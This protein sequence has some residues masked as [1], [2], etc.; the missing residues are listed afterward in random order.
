MYHTYWLAMLCGCLDMVS[1]IIMH[2]KAITMYPLSYI[3]ASYHYSVFLFR[4]KICLLPVIEMNQK[5]A[6]VVVVSNSSYISLGHE[7]YRY[8]SY[9]AIVSVCDSL[10]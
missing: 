10:C 3:P 7:A 6:D 5:L 8:S 9:I 4:K 1:H 2:T